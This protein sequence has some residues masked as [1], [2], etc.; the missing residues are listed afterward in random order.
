VVERNNDKREILTKF[1]MLTYHRTYFYHKKN[2]TY[3]YLVDEALG[4]APYDRV[5]TAVAADM[6]EYS[7]DNSYAK[8]SQYATGGIVSQANRNEQNKKT[9]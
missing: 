6:V 2:D 5:S 7:S 1:G 3:I 9:K 8:S 4:I